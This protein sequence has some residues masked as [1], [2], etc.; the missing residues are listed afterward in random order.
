[1]P[2]GS[3]YEHLHF[4]A[5]TTK[6]EADKILQKSGDLVWVE[7][8]IAAPPAAVL[9]KLVDFSSWSKWNLV[10]PCVDIANPDAD[11]KLKDVSTHPKVKVYLDFKKTGKPMAAEPTVLLNDERGFGWGLKVLGGAMVKAD[12]VFLALPHDDGKATRFVHY[13]RATGAFGFYMKH[14]GHKIMV[15]AYTEFNESL[16][17]YVEEGPSEVEA[18]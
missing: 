12:H 3:A 10:I 16:K 5:V 8:I 13:E 14:F 15:S 17:K 6:E 2:S 4:E 18:A 1:M 9:E 7:T 11:G